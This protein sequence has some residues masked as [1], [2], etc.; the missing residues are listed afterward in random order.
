[1]RLLKNPKS[2]RYAFKAGEKLSESVDW[3]QKGVV[4]PG[5]DQGQCR[6]CWAFSTVSAVEGIN[7]IVTGKLISLS[8]QE[9][10]DCDKSYNQGCN[11][12]FMNSLKI[13][14]A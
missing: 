13:T 6:S 5:K 1:M 14:V 11:S 4:A 7:Q 9:L 2:E 12:G 10:V 3:R 8:E